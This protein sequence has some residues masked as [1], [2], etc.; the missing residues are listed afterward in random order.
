MD[1]ICVKAG[2]NYDPI[3]TSTFRA[4]W[5]GSR[6]T[7]LVGTHA[8]VQLVPAGGCSPTSASVQVTL[9]ADYTLKPFFGMLPLEQT[10]VAHGSAVVKVKPPVLSL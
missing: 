7:R 9:R 6:A 1:Q 4:N 2:P 8:M 10:M 5:R 3:A